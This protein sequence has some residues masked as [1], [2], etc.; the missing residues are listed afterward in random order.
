MQTV[1][2]EGHKGG[3]PRSDPMVRVAPTSFTPSQRPRTFAAM[4][5][6]L[7]PSH[8]TMPGSPAPA[9]RASAA[10]IT[11]RT[12]VPVGRRPRRGTAR[13]WPPPRLPVRRLVRTAAQSGAPAPESPV[14]RSPGQLDEPLEGYICAH[15]LVDV[16][17]G[18]REVEQV[19]LDPCDHVQ[20]GA[21]PRCPPGSARHGPRAP[22]YGRVP[23]YLSRLATV[24]VVV[25]RLDGENGCPRLAM[26]NSARRGQGRRHEDSTTSSRV[27]RCTATKNARTTSG[28]GVCEIGGAGR[29]RTADLR[30]AKPALQPV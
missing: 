26:Q 12:R 3:Q 29:V 16:Q 2:G 17:V 24:T 20:A 30:P 22:W 13:P 1:P 23:L 27:S 28:S 9:A 25:T 8:A 10:G 21:R 14:A 11:W 15:L 7:T 6:C 4:A 18:H 5:S 19:F